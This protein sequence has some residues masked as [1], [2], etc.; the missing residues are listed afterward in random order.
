M[1]ELPLAAGAGGAGRARDPMP[2]ISPSATGLPRPPARSRGDALDPDTT[3]QGFGA[4]GGKRLQR[5]FTT[6]P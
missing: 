4:R 6:G 1:L 3:L 5:Y 2:D